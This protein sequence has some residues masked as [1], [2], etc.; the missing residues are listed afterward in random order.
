MWTAAKAGFKAGLK[1]AFK[2]E[3]IAAMIPDVVLMIADK[4]AARE[5]ARAIRRK[6][7]KEGFAKGVAAGVMEWTQ[8]E[9][10]ANLMNHVTMFRV[11]GMAD[12]AGFLTLSYILRLAETSENYA[13]MLGYEFSRQKSLEWRQAMLKDAIGAMRNR[14]FVFETTRPDGSKTY[15]RQPSDD[16]FFEYDFIDKLSGMIA[17]KTDPIVEQ[18]M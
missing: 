10:S 8:G 16:T 15:S 14:D 13:V 4:V 11:Q 1:E 5:A 18:A 17:P 6:F 2:A 9:V 12:P 3:N 7:T